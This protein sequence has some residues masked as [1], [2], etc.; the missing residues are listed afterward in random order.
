MQIISPRDLIARQTEVEKLTDREPV[1]LKTDD[2]KELVVMSRAEFDRLKRRDQV[3]MS[4]ADI[5]DWLA[6]GIMNAPIP[7]EAEALDYLME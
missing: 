6:H 4:V 2:G 1:S 7:P 5:P 3:A